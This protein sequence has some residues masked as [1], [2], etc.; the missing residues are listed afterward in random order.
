MKRK[1]IDTLAFFTTQEL[2]EEIVN[3]TTFVGVVI[4]SDQEH[5]NSAQVHDNFNTFA[6]LESPDKVVA[7]LTKVADRI[8]E[9]SG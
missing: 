2:I 1:R 9:G 4:Q 6:S 7:V 8:K 3:R 5:K